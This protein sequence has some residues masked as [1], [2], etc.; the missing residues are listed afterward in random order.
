MDPLQKQM[1]DDVFDAFSMLSNGAIVSMMHVQGN[2]TRWSPDAVETFGLS[3]EYLNSAVGEWMDRVHQKDR[4]YFAQHWDEM[5]HGEHQ[6]FDLK[7]YVR[8]KDGNFTFCSVR[9]GGLLINQGLTEMTDP[10]TVL[11]N[12]NAFNKDLGDLIGS[13]DPFY[14]LQVGT[15]HFNDINNIHG[16]SF[17]NRV[18]QEMAWLIQDTVKSRGKVYR[19]KEATFA[20]L[21]VKSVSR[22]QAA[23]IYDHIRYLFQRGIMVNG[24]KNILSANGGLISGFGGMN[25]DSDASYI[26]SCLNYA[27]EESMQRSHGDLVD[28]NGSINYEGTASLDLISRIRD[29]IINDCEGFRLE[30]DPV[31]GVENE[32][33]KGAEASIFWEDEKHG[34]VSPDDFIPL[35]ERDLI[36][37]ELGDFILE[38]A[39][40]D[41]VKLMT[42]DPA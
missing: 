26:C 31:I 36:F 20:V 6:S 37:E 19:I 33:L 8:T 22:D 18:L 15:G 27:Y 3:G 32:E 28:F 35:L 16:Y 4:D 29:C 25:S 38:N 9:V 12:A 30:Y 39:L 1:L 2:T 5:T 21:F 24:V 13:N 34:R 17:G 14:A 7:Y 10:V 42:Y 40:K 11:P 23:A 41:S